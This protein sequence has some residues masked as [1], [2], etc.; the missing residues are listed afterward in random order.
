V[1]RVAAS[2]PDSAPPGRVAS[3]AAAARGWEAAVGREMG[4]RLGGA[5]AGGRPAAGGWRLAGGRRL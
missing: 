4:R 1:S 2:G 3:L 5:M